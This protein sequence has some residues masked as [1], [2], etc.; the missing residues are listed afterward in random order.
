VDKSKK[1]PVEVASSKEDEVAQG[2]AAASDKN[3][4][5]SGLEL[6]KEGVSRLNKTT[7]TALPE[8]GGAALIGGGKIIPFRGAAATQESSKLTNEAVDVIKRALEL[9]DT[10]IEAIDYL[11]DSL[12]ADEYE[13]GLAMLPAIG[14]GLESMENTKGVILNKDI[15][16]VDIGEKCA[17]SF[18]VVA[19]AFEDTVNAAVEGGME[20]FIRRSGYMKTTYTVWHDAINTN[21]RSLSVM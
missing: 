21:L 7:A 8:S 16:A 6:L 20:E 18:S 11:V 13:Q 19:S 15:L 14:E 3:I 2:K 9:S 10:I 1:P 17:A 4:A 5:A 12:S